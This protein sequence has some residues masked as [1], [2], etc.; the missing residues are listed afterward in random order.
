MNA[1]V[2][3]AIEAR[4]TELDARIEQEAEVHTGY[5]HQLSLMKPALD[6]VASRLA[7]LQSEREELAAAL[8]TE[9]EPEP[10]EEEA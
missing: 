5:V 8:P 9:V 10:E 1:A 2:R 4:I 3:A 6:A 7:D